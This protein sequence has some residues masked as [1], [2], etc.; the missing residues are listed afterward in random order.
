MKGMGQN[1]KKTHC[2]QNTRL[3]QAL[4]RYFLPT[5]GE[6][7]FQPRYPTVDYLGRAKVVIIVTNIFPKKIRGHQNQ[8]KTICTRKSNFGSYYGFCLLTVTKE[9]MVFKS[10]SNEKLLVKFVK[11]TLFYKVRTNT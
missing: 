4:V 10:L 7:S 6:T 5:Y 11:K 2:I 9:D 1:G 3:L 8:N